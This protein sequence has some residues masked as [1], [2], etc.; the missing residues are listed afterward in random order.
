[1]YFW[2]RRK[3]MLLALLGMLSFL[4]IIKVCSAFL[5][6]RLILS[7]DFCN[8]Y[9]EIMQ[10]SEMSEQLDIQDALN[11]NGCLVPYVYVNNTYYIS[12]DYNTDSW[13]GYFSANDGYQ[14]YFHVDDMWNQKKEAISSG[15]RF[16]VLVQYGTEYKE[17]SLVVSGLPVIAVTETNEIDRASGFVLLDAEEKN[18]YEG[19]CTSHTR[20]QTSTIYPKKGFKI[21]LCTE[22]TEKQTKT[23][24]LG[25]RSDNDWILNPMYTDSSKIREKLAYQ[26]WEDMQEYRQTK[27]S[28]SNITYVEFIF[29]HMYYG[30]YGLM[31]PVDKKQLSMNESDVFYRKTDLVVPTLEEITLY[32]TDEAERIPGFCIKY[33]KTKDIKAEDWQLLKAYV[34]AFY[35]DLGDP[36]AVKETDWKSLSELVDIDNAIDYEILLASISGSDN[37][38]KNIDYCLRYEDGKYVMHMIPWDMDSTFGALGACSGMEQENGRTNTMMVSREFAT[39]YRADNEQMET[40]LREQWKKYRQS[41]LST[42]Y[43]QTLAQS[44]MEELVL[45]G[46]MER[47]SEKWPECNNYTDLSNFM[48]YIEAHMECLDAVFEED[49]WWRDNVYIKSEEQWNE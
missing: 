11:F 49:E 15:H 13:N 35:Y 1:M 34:N 22:D 5:Q 46:A 47:D 18:S 43:L 7:M 9:D 19:F 14:V 26:M 40:L 4:G 30:I 21:N 48:E 31:E 33:P 3:K 45:S 24:M 42:E 28:S 25:L 23:S 44:Y 41:I 10:G 17:A 8:N 6:N 27:D 38:F 29:D 37:I 2:N 36:S 12:Q 32:G 16:S 39:L 20:G